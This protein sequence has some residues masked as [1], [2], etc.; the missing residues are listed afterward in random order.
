MKKDARELLELIKSRIVLE[1]RD[2]E[3]LRQ[4]YD[5]LY[6][7]FPSTGP[8]K[9]RVEEDAPVTSYWIVTPESSQEK[10]LLFFH[11]GLF[12][13]GSTHSHQDLCQQLSQ[14]TSCSILSVDY[15]LAPEHPFPAAL[16]D[17]LDS[18]LWLVKKGFRPQDIV[19]TGI[20]AGGNL[21]L[22][23]LLALKRKEEP[24]PQAMVGLS[25]IVDLTFPVVYQHLKDVEDWIDYDSLHKLMGSYI[26]GQDPSNF[27]LSPVNGDLE[28]LPPIF[29]QAGSCELLLCDINQFRDLAIEREV[30]VNLEV[31]Q[32]MFH[33]WQM[34]PSHLAEAE[35]SLESVG[36]FVRSLE[37]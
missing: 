22:S 7:S 34:F 5:E 4:D 20:S 10:V 15:R 1:K 27:L 29:L 13:M 8:F 37:D 17:A 6:L 32:G 24:L 16:E 12:N 30:K 35:Q 26:W 9:L 23:T 31:W 11:G 14:V 21:A 18:Y 36:E 28:G 33:A 19:V 25:P 3:R 2:P